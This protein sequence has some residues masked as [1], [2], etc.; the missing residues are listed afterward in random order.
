MLSIIVMVQ[1]VFFYGNKQFGI[2]FPEVPKPNMWQYIWLTSLI[3][4]LAGYLSLNKSRL[5]LMNFYYKGTVCLGLGT[6]LATMVLN[7]S[8]LLEYAQTKKTNN[9]YHDFPVIVLWYMYLFVVIQ[10]H[11]FGIFFAR[12]LINAWSKDG[13]KRS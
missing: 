13:K 4:A 10:I 6:V 7:A 5:S 2:Q 1:I 12:T 3:P 8:D 9:L 11:A